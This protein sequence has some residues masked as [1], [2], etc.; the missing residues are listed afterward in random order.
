[1]ETYR[2]EVNP[3]LLHG[4]YVERAVDVPQDLGHNP[5]S[6][7]QFVSAPSLSRAEA[8]ANDLVETYGDEV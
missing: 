4:H 1:M 8:Y 2:V 5:K 6:L 3:N 7:V